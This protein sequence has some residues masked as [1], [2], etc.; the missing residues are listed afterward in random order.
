LVSERPWFH[1]V[2][3]PII[4]EERNPLVAELVVI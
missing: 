1:G 2:F 4:A 3:A